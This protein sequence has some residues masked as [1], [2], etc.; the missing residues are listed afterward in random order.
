MVGVTRLP[1]SCAYN[2]F[3]ADFLMIGVHS[4][5]LLQGFSFGAAAD[6]SKSIS[7]ATEALAKLKESLGQ[8]AIASFLGQQRLLD[9][10][11]YFVSKRKDVDWE[12]LNMRNDVR[13]ELRKAV[14]DAQGAMDDVDVVDETKFVKHM[15]EVATKWASQ[16][17]DIDRLIQR[18]EKAFEATGSDFK[19][20]EP[21]D[22]R[23]A[24][25]TSG[26]IMFSI[27]LYTA[28]T[29]YRSSFMGKK[30]KAG[31]QTL[32]N[33]KKVL[34]SI[35]AKP[36]CA[37]WENTF[38]LPATA[39]MRKFAKVPL[40]IPKPTYT[41]ETLPP[42]AVPSAAH[43][44]AMDAHAGA[45]AAAQKEELR[46][47]TN[48]EDQA[49]NQADRM[50]VDQKGNQEEEPLETTNEEDQAAKKKD[51]MEEDREEEHHKEAAKKKDQIE[52]DLE[53]LLA[54]DLEALE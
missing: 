39:E 31:E 32:A 46:K 30:G 8:E 22:H 50:E 21:K 5:T 18:C 44:D 45:A 3:F 36:T 34:E 2:T 38:K 26:G 11:A 4:A 1:Q 41:T 23:D 27:S 10:E 48:E 6:L 43:H 28:I 16:Q 15:R 9:V 12:I 33:L 47:N 35:N 20:A 37:D 54:E 42:P 13:A 40:Q 24:H 52:E 7:T 14:V 49:D 51:Q 53:A 19:S 29:L 25:H 17:R